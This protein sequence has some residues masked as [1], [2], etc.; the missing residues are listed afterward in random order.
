M[1]KMHF[2]QMRDPA[3]MV[4]LFLDREDTT[5]LSAPTPD[6]GTMTYNSFEGEIF[7]NIRHT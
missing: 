5:P 3:D 7:K 4:H 2:G 1:F 6:T